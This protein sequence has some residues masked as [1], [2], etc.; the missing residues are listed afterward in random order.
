VSTP[1]DDTGADPARTA[2]LAATTARPPAPER[3]ADDITAADHDLGEL[4]IVDPDTYVFGHYFARGGMGRIAKVRDKRL[5]RV[6]AIKELIAPDPALVARFKREIQITA[7]LQHPSI[8]SI[9]EAGRWPSGEPFFAMKHVA[10]QSLKQAIEARATLDERLGLLA[11]VIALVDALAYAHDHGVIHRDLKPANVLVG[12]FGETVVIDWGLAK[13]LRAGDDR[14]P[15]PALA[16]ATAAHVTVAGS[17]VG[18]PAYM[19]PEQA[20][21]EDVDARSDVYALGTILYTVLAGAPPYDGPTPAAVLARVLD[22]PPPA[23]GVRQPGV[24]DD[25]Q[26]IVARAMEREPGDRYPSA[27]ELAAD[28]KRFQTGQLVATHRYSRR[29]LIAR[30]VRRH[31]GAVVV[32]AAALAALAALGAASFVGIVGERD[33]ARA[34]ERD[35]SA[36]ADSLVIAQ[37]R[38]LAETD[39]LGALRVLA[40]LPDASTQWPA[41]RQIAADAIAGGLPRPIAMPELGDTGDAVVSPDGRWIAIVVGRDVAIV[42]VLTGA[43]R[44]LGAAGG[45][46]HGAR[47]LDLEIADDGAHLASASQDNTVIVWTV[48]DDRGVALRGH[49]GWVLDVEMLPGGRQ[50]ISRGMDGKS[51][52]WSIDG[53]EAIRAFDA[54]LYGEDA[55]ADGRRTLGLDVDG[56]GAALWDLTTG[57]RGPLVDTK[58]VVLGP[59]G[60]TL[61]AVHDKRTLRL[62]PIAGPARPLAELTEAITELAWYGDG[63]IVVGGARGALQRLDADGKPRWAYRTDGEVEGLARSADGATIAAWSET[64]AVHLVDAE[65]GAGRPL[66]GSRGDATFVAGGRVITRDRKGGFVV[67]P[68]AV[69]DAV[70]LSA[71]VDARAIAIAPDG[72]RVAA[73]GPDSAVRIWDERGQATE[74]A[75]H[76]GTVTHVVFSPNGALLASIGLDKRVRLWEAATG[77]GV[78]L[79]E[80]AVPPL[81]FAPDGARL[82]AAGDS[83]GVRVWQVATGATSVL[84]TAGDQVASI[85]FTA[86]GRL[87]AGGRDGRVRTW[88]AGGATIAGEHGGPIRSVAFS[89]DGAW[90]ASAGEDGAIRLWPRAG[91]EPRALR[92]HA[93]WVAAIAFAPRGDRLASIG[94]D[95]TVRIWDVA[96]GTGRVLGSHDEAG[97]DVAFA[98]DGATIAT[99]GIDR[100]ARL[101]DVATGDHRVLRGHGAWLWAVR[102]F[103]DGTRLATLGNDGTLRIWP[104]DLPREPAALRAWIRAAAQTAR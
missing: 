71:H 76:L 13:D 95:R 102:Y 42:D 83:G 14:D 9:H 61:A 98:P 38:T 7:R 39:A 68:V 43:A 11:S 55:T 1:P 97:V 65:T 26:A 53:G 57:T 48:A 21:G 78:T 19:S 10:G 4:P 12:E 81:A 29:E 3:T 56:K 49:V 60:S 23:V 84:D 70:V 6:V 79:P 88:L 37:A 35:A 90:L 50:L 62:H 92:G 74:L 2:T 59:D 82:V 67:W 58:R 15:L 96:T 18:T 27:K 16:A 41:A 32:A 77:R 44:T 91:G 24:P 93:S 73:G 99:A 75:G 85:A 33:R 52:L 63:A 51:R 86:D 89:A 46:R 66:A 31:R 80:R 100:T 87:A 45:V 34:A 25:L 36:R 69:G 17:V 94:V 28:L 8:V 64:G 30:W 47:I 72:T 20:R 40:R 101:W 22:G 104:D 103:P 5:G 54:W